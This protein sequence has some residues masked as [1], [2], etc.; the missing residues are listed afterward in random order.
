MEYLVVCLVAL[1][2]SA[3][4]LFSGFGLGTLLLPAFLVFFPA[5]LAVGMTAVVHFLNNIFKFVLLG[6]LADRSVVLSFGLPSIAASFAGAWLLVTA[7]DAPSLGSYEAFGQERMLLPVN[8]VIGVLITVFAFLELPQQRKRPSAGTRQL[9]V[10]GLLSGFF[11]G[12]SG[13]QG[14]LRSAFLLR[15]G[16]SREVFI[17]SGVVISCLVDV[18]RIGVYAEHLIGRPEAVPWNLVA[19]AAGSAFVGAVAGR[20]TMGAVTMEGIRRLIAVLLIIVGA[21]VA[22]GLL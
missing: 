6:R 1:L 22:S 20:M 13:H 15:V 8:I 19:A 7:S 2:A 12:L 9:V 16:L 4:T 21:G 17:A 14:A 3:L 10:G 18:S 5:E 11:G